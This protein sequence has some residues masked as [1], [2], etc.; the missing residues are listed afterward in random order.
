VNTTV[1]GKAFQFNVCCR[2]CTLTTNAGI[3]LL[4]DFIA[5][6]QLPELLDSHIHVKARQRGYP[7]SQNLLALCWNAILGG[8]CLRDLDVLR[9]DAGICQLLGISS[10][11]AP[12]T[13]GEFLRQF[14]IGDI[15]DLRRVNRLAAQ[16]L[17]PLQKSKQVTIDLDAS[18]Y[19]Q[20]STR[21][22]GSRMNDKGEVGYYPLFAF[23][24]EEKE[25]LATHL[26]SGNRNAPPK[27][28]WFLEQ[29]LAT[30]PSHKARFLRADSEFYVWELLEFCEREGIIYTITADQSVSMK[31]AIEGLSES[32]W[33]FYA[34]GMQVAELFY[35]PVHRQLHRYVVKRQWVKEGR[36]QEGWRYHVIVT[37]AQ[38]R[39]ARKLMKWS[40]QRCAMEN[41]IKEHKRDFGFEK[42]PSQ[43]YH[44]NWAW[45]LVSQLA[46]NVMMWFVRSCLPGECH[47][48]Q[49]SSL[50]HRLLKVAGKLVSHGR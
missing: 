33:K 39:G 50:R 21:K 47:Q 30:A 9:G 35:Q 24:A 45:L 20:C 26:M 46:W 28:I 5:R 25:M 48:M 42:M 11:M 1:L 49:M 37:N 14:D 43:K 29:A 27:V 8:N 16:G 32:C 2:D 10:L 22:Q 31:A 36:K 19:Q 13:A 40:L 34:V 6:L 4:R 12:T 44:G 15:C 7:E 3:V 41:L 18:L 38:K 23:W 17:R